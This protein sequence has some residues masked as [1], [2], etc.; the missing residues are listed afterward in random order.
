MVKELSII[1]KESVSDLKQLNLL[2]V[3]SATAW[4]GRRGEEEVVY[5]AGICQ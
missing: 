1:A 3:S 4:R 2:L 5:D